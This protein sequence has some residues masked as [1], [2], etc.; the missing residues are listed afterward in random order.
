MVRLLLRMKAE[1]ENVESVEFPPDYT[2]NIDVTQSGGSE[3][4]KGVTL[5]AAEEFE[6]PNSRGTANLVMRFGGGKSVATINVEQTADSSCLSSP[7]NA[8][9]HPGSL[10]LLH[11][12]QQQHDACFL[13]QQ[14]QREQERHQCIS[15]SRGTSSSSRSR[16]MFA[17]C[18]VSVYFR[19]EPTSWT[20]TSG[21]LVRSEKAQFAGVDLAEDWADFDEVEA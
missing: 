19:V 6:I 12:P 1:L 9:G 15:G 20:P 11:P 16:K 18:W 4:K 10:T 7:S 8:A 2:Y 14:Q 5:S 17:A 3:E 13:Q 21:C